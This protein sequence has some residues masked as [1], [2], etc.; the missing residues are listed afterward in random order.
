MD[1]K[2]QL[3]VEQLLQDLQSVDA[4]TKISAAKEL[5][6]LSWSNEQIVTALEKVALSDINKHV[7]LA[8]R[9][10]LDAPVHQEVLKQLG[11]RPIA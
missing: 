4:F 6:L 2:D 10:T 1:Q 11:P 8:A 7:V 3:F 9:E 5:R